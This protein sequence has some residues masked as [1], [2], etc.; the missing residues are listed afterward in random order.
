MMRGYTLPMLTS[1]HEIERLAQIVVQRAGDGAAD[2]AR[3]LV[4]AMRRQGYHDEADTWLR[5]IAAID[6]LGTA[7]A[8]AQLWAR[9]V[10]PADTPTCD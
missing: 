1:D 6:A 4:E 10:Y 8:S 7:P 5:V 2:K 9:A 3:K